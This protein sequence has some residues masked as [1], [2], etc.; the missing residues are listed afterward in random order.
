MTAKRKEGR[1]EGERGGEGRGGVGLA[2]PVSTFRKAP[3][4]VLVIPAPHSSWNAEAGESSALGS[5]CQ[6]GRTCV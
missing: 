2:L 3:K 5:P 6:D 4:G 1:E